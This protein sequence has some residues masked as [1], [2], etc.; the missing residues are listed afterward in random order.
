M[1]VIHPRALE[2]NRPPSAV[3]VNGEHREVDDGVFEVDDETWLHGFAEA[4]GMDPD[5]LL[6]EEDQPPP[7]EEICTVVKNDGEICGREK[8]CPY[9]SDTDEEE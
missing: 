7:D 4:H 3:D 6:L 2:D 1:Q 5:D 8:P 9:H